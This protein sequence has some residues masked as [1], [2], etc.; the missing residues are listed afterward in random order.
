M[1]HCRL[2]IIFQN[3]FFRKIL[4][5]IPFECENSLGLDQDQHFVQPDLGPNC[6]QKLSEDDTRRHRV[7]SQTNKNLLQQK[8]N[9]SKCVCKHKNA[10]GSCAIRYSYI[11]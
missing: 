1:L 2:L 3:P 5:G 9:A 6:L 7:K 10:P 4:S 11:E 8:S